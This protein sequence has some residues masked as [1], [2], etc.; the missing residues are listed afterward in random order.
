MESRSLLYLVMS[1][2]TLPIPRAHDFLKFHWRFLQGRIHMSRSG[3]PAR[4]YCEGAC[5]Q[6]GDPPWG[7]AALLVCWQ[8][9]P[10]GPILPLGE[11]RGAE[12]PCRQRRAGCVPRWMRESF[13]WMLFRER[14][15]LGWAAPRTSPETEHKRGTLAKVI[16]V[17]IFSTSYDCSLLL[18]IRIL[19]LT[20]LWL[21]E[22]VNFKVKV[23]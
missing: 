5:V 17:N 3:F 22:L 11:R 6:G 14:L 7:C 13:A 2:W 10:G 4:G 20:W 21:N 1:N 16:T 15:S 18:T 19:L 9:N 12:L 23:L 8:E